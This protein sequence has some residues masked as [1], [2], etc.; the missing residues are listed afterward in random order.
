MDSRTP[1]KGH[2]ASKGHGLLL[3]WLAVVVSLA[4]AFGTGFLAYRS[5][6]ASDA[7]RYRVTLEA[8]VDGTRV[9]GSGVLAARVHAL[10]A[11]DMT[12]EA[13]TLDL[14]DRRKVFAIFRPSLS[15]TEQ[16]FLDDAPFDAVPSTAS[17]LARV[18]QL[19]VERP[20]V[21]LQAD[22]LPTLVRFRDIGDPSSLELVDPKNLAATYGRGVTLRQVTFEITDDA[23]TNGIETT[24][25][26]LAALKASGHP[27]GSH[28]D[29][30]SIGE[31]DLDY[32]C[33]KRQRE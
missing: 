15:F 26:W 20:R 29:S 5:T 23:V 30:T 31:P 3:A 4:L 22:K 17:P 21:D 14:G 1:L 16:R 8:D 19:K 12:G 11:F 32:A 28:T 24:L 33:F 9:T 7:L 18:R 10:G 25:P 27:I 6:F 2:V 13:I